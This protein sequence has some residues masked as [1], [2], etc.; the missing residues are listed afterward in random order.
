MYH[1]T[2][3]FNSDQRDSLSGPGFAPL[4]CSLVIASSNP[5]EYWF[6]F[7]LGAGGA[8]KSTMT[9]VY[10]TSHARKIL[11]ILDTH[12]DLNSIK[13]VVSP[14][15]RASFSSESSFLNQESFFL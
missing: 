2:I 12:C 8:K 7:W 14:L 1:Y 6:S 10:G 9:H 4:I 3:I 5:V 13:E 11:V 15:M